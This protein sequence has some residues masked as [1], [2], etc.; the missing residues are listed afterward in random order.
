LVERIDREVDHHRAGRPARIRFKVNS[1][2]DEAIIDAL[3][4]ASQAGVPIDLWVRGICR[5]RPG[6][7]GLSET[8][9]VRSILGRYLEH[10]RVFS[11]A[12]GEDPQVFIGSADI[13]HR[14][15]DRRIETLVR[16]SDLGQLEE[17]AALFDLAMSDHTASWWLEE[18]GEWTRHATTAG[19]D[20]LQDLQNVVMQQISAR[21]RGGPR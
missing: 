10:S 21:K 15:L 19:G 12:N 17:I 11:F 16:L 18:S 9:R 8:I 13:M 7:E 4:R 2:V 3:Y 5:V 6:V 20:E 14:N 1:I